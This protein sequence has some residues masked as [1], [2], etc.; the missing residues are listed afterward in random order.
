MKTE[1]TID[2][3]MVPRIKEAA[4]VGRISFSAAVEQAVLA[5]LPFLPK[6]P[7]RKPYHVKPHSFGTPL[8]DPKAV[9]AELE[10]AEDIERL[11]RAGG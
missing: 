8:P 2:D 11:K 7:V 3:A 10:E 1:I 9:F 4:E 5:G 6:K